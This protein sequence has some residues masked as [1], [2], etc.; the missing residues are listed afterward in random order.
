MYI[1]VNKD[2]KMGKGKIAAQAGHVVMLATEY[3]MSNDGKLYSDYKAGGM[4]KIVLNATVELLNEFEGC[5]NMFSVRDFGRTQVEP[6]T[7]TAIATLPMTQ[8][9][10][11][12]LY[13]QIKSLKLV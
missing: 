11:D 2:A 13:P 3:M 9:Q 6:N 8:E 7:L 1:L 12:E 10:L 4:P 5:P